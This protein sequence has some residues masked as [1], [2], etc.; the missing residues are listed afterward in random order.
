MIQYMQCIDESRCE[1]IEEK[2]RCINLI[3]KQ[4]STKVDCWVEYERSMPKNSSSANIIEMC[5][6]GGLPKGGL[7]RDIL[8]LH[9]QRLRQPAVRRARR[10]LRSCAALIAP[11][12]SR[13]C[14]RSGRAAAERPTAVRRHPVVHGHA[15]QPCRLLRRPHCAAVPAALRV[16]C[17]AREIHQENMSG[18]RAKGVCWV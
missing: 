3:E 1:C 2:V 17:C 7:L 5:R 12:D 14:R 10:R 9:H 8:P 16:V 11:G 6:A 4:T 13:H 15:A 18:F